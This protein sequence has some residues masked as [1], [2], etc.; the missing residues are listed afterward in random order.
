MIRKIKLAKYPWFIFISGLVVCVIIFFAGKR[1]IIYSSTDNYCQSCHIHPEADN[2]WKRSTH[3]F[4]KSGVRVH[5][6]ECH[7]PPK[8]D[9]RYLFEKAKTGLSD[10]YGFYFKDSAS[11]NWEH[12]RSLEYAVNIVYNKSCTKCHQNLFSKG[13]SPDGGTAHLLLCKKRRKD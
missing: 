11:F 6:V 2:S 3:F 10:L 8:D 9:S 7:L 13:L 12:R 4:N 1:A 5:C